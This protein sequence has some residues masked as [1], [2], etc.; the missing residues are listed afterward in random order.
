MFVAIDAVGIRSGGG[1]AVLCELLHWL[2]VVRPDWT[3]H[4]FVLPRNQREFDDPPVAA[5]VTLESVNA[6]QTDIDRLRWLAHRLP[7]RVRQLGADVLFCFANIGCLRP[8]APQVSYCHQMLAFHEEL[9]GPNLYTR[10][11]LRFIR[12]CLL[13]GAAASATVIVQTE[14]MRREVLRAKPSLGDRILVI[15]AGHR[16]SADAFVVRPAKVRPL[17]EPGYPKLIYFAHLVEY[18]NH[19]VL[20]QA[21]R[22][23]RAEFPEVKLFLSVDRRQR[24]ARRLLRVVEEAGVAPHVVWLG[25]LN[26]AEV[27][28]SLSRSHLMVY[29]SL[30]ESFGL[31]LVEAMAAGCPIAAADLPYAHEVAGG[32]AAYFDPCSPESLAQCVVQTLRASFDHGW[33][34]A[35]ARERSRLFDYSRITE[36]IAKVLEHSK[37]ANIHLPEFAF[38]RGQ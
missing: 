11:R 36:A 18:K 29:P 1:P 6:A 30:A 14:A 27:N 12:L 37:P 15:P 35:T 28:Y 20:V 19:P 3:F 2:P 10:L 23:I 16:T 17:D 31:P 13:R 7:Q 9:A 5:S 25:S 38:I 34:A 26:P 24:Q 33:P 21:L 32:A 22:W 8:A 4:V